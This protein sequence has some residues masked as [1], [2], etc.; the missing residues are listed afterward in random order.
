MII[1]GCQLILKD[2][3]WIC[4]NVVDTPSMTD[5][6]MRVIE[7]KVNEKIRENAPLTV[8]IVERDDPKLK[9]VSWSQIKILNIVHHFIRL[10]VWFICIY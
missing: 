10:S 4:Y 8:E 5:D 2:I 6:E 9:S 1:G 3:L 7:E